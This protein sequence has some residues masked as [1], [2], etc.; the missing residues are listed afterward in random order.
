MS[1]WSVTRK[2]ADRAETDPQADGIALMDVLR[3][4]DDARGELERLFTRWGDDPVAVMRQAQAR[5]IEMQQLVPQATAL[6]ER[7][8]MAHRA[9]GTFSRPWASRVGG[10]A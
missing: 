1:D 10:D 8:M 2:S 9:A 3:R 5:T 4:L 7:L 6:G